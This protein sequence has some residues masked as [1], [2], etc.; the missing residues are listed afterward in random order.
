MDAFVKIWPLLAFI[1]VQSFAAVWWASSI[2]KTVQ[3]LEKDMEARAD[4]GE[5]IAAMKAT[6]KG[7]NEKL[8]MVLTAINSRRRS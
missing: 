3:R 2:S 7:M 5:D 4:D 8:D 6:L 1:I